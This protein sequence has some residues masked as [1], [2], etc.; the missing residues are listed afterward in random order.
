MERPRPDRLTIR[1]DPGG[2]LHQMALEPSTKATND[3][4]QT[5]PGTT[6]P[7]EFPGASPDS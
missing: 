7:P 4:Q 6:K 3:A 1:V 5:D 2:V